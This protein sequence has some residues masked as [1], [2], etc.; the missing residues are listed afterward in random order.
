[1]KIILV[2]TD[3]SAS[4]H[5]ASLYALS[6]AK[7]IDARIILFNAYKVPQ[8]APSVNVGISSYDIMM[9]TD[10][11]L[12]DEADILDQSGKII[13]IVCDEGIA[14][15]AIV[16]I[17][18]EKKVDLI[19]C[20]MN[21]ENKNLKRIFGTTASALAK[22]SKVPVIIIPENAEF[23]KTDVL[24]F[25]TENIEKEI[26]ARLKE[27]ARSLHS[28][29]YR[30]KIVRNE[31]VFQENGEHVILK[32]QPGSSNMPERSTT[33]EYFVDDDITSS[34]NEFINL[35]HA[36]MVAMIPHKH[37]WLERIFMKSETKEMI[38]HTHIPL[39]ILPEN[40]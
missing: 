20:G 30:I 26:L 15:E 33:L 37:G 12:L 32:G 19:V 28:K 38:F 24:V 34:L 17:A 36:D 2:A 27:L 11:K 35:K 1:M 29:M 16:N 22:I 23:K 25:A 39:L 7:E 18:H 8:P 40:T 3:F 10:R 9:Q 5:N 13:E 21:G 31:T 14:E 6:L 4:A